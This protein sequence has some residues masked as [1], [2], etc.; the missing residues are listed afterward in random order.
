MTIAQD[1]E[2]GFKHDVH[3]LGQGVGTLKA[4]LSNLAHEAADAARSGASELRQGAHHAVEAAKEKFVEA[5]DVVGEKY[6]QAKHAA[7]EATDFLKATI[8]RNPITSVGVAAGVGLIAGMYAVSW[9]LCRSRSD[10]AE[11]DQR[12]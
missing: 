10:R 11:V 12:R 9:M 7:V 8:T 1:E 2:T 5:R 6:D 3:A 4:D